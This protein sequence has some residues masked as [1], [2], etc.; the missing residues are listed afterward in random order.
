MQ[1]L[2]SR[3]VTMF[4]LLVLFL[5]YLVFRNMGLYPT[6]FADEYSYSMFSR[7][8]PLSES[9]VP[10]YIYLKLYSVTNACGDGFL[11]CAKLINAFLFILAAPF[12]F[13]IARRVAS[14]TASVVVSLLAVFGPI[15]SYTAYFMP[16]SFYFLSFWVFSW[17]LLSLTADSRI[18]KW[19]FYG[20]YVFS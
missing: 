9:S 19:F 11:G 2:N 7:L 10:S 14:E 8:L 13:L 6:V 18:Y 12:I 5:V 16:E 17:Y 4:F 1:N 20:F 3:I 15:N